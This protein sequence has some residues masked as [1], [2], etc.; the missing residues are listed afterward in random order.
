MSA[1]GATVPAGAPIRVLFVHAADELY[2]SDVILL[3]IV[4]GL[5]PRRA[6]ATVVLP[7]DLPYEGR[8]TSALRDAGVPVRSMRLGVLRRRYYTPFGML[9]FASALAISTLRL[10]RLIRRQRVDVVH[11]HTAAVF[12]GALAAR[13]AGRPHVW[14]V[15][16]IVERPRVVNRALA[17]VVPALADRVVAVSTAVV[18]AMRS[19]RPRDDA[20]WSVIHN[21]IDAE[22]F[23]AG[24]RAAARA[25]LRREAGIPADAVVV[26]MIGRV[27]TWKGQELLLD[28]FVQVARADAG[29]RLLL[30]GG[31]VGGDGAMDVLRA[32]VAE[33]GVAER[34]VVWG[35]RGDVPALL[36]A[37]D[38]FVQPSL[39]PDPFPTT[40][41]EAMSAG[42]PVVAT[43]HGGPAEMLVEGESGFLT[44]PGDATEMADRILELV[45][46]S[47]LRSAM[48]AAGA[49]RVRAEYGIAGFA[50]RYEAI[51]A[52]LAEVTGRRGR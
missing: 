47:R 2:G 34:T 24:D 46:D 23:V 12:S 16:E 20:R 31:G 4:R 3:A 21:G 30:V 17:R 13:L 15:S 49:T 43:A 39:N 22:R 40:V 42:L 25:A 19:G 9:R 41:L 37:M 6:V 36:A 28:A 18:A 33:L 5:D 32:R 10:A 52:S 29:A 35:F 27:G 11:S 38:V 51:Y 45:R 7:N 8:L 1:G 48:G 44:A 50:A 14:H 26:G